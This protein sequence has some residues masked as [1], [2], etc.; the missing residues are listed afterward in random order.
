MMNCYVCD[1]SI[2]DLK[3][4]FKHL[5]DF[6]SISEESTEFKCGYKSCNKT[7]ATKRSIREHIMKCDFK[8][9]QNV[10]SSVT[11]SCSSNFSLSEQN[12]SPQDVYGNSDLYFKFINETRVDQ[13]PSNELPTNTFEAKMKNEFESNVKLKIRNLVATLSTKLLPNCII[14]LTIKNIISILESVFLYIRSNFLLPNVRFME[15]YNDFVGFQNEILHEIKSLSTSYRRRKAAFENVPK[16][17]EVTLGVRFDRKFDKKLQMFIEKPIPDNLIYISLISTL[18]YLFNDKSVQQYISEGKFTE[19]GIYRDISDGSFMKRS[20]FYNVSDKRILIHI[21][22]DDFETVNGLGYK[23]GIH[24][25]TPIYFVIKNLPPYLQS[26]LQNIH[27]L[28]L[29]NAQDTKFYGYNN[30]LFCVVQELKFLE[31]IGIEIDFLQQKTLKGSLVALSGDYIGANGICGMVESCRAENFCRICLVDHS[32]MSTVFHESQVTLRTKEEHFAHAELAEKTNSIVNGVK[33]SCILNE[34][35]YFNS[36]DAP[37]CDIMHDILEGVGQWDEKTFFTF[38]TQNKILTQLEIN[39]KIAAFNFGTLESTSLPNSVSFDKTGVGLKAAQT[40][41]LIRHT[42]L[43]FK[44]I[45][46]RNDDAELKNV[47]QLVVLLNQIM[48]IIFAPTITEEMIQNLEILIEV[49]H[50]LYLLCNAEK[51]LKPK[52]HFMIHYPNIIRKMGPLILLWC[53]RFEGKHLPFKKLA[54]CTQNFV[55]IC[56]TFAFRHQESLYFHERN[57]EIDKNKLSFE[58]DTK[59]DCFKHLLSSFPANEIFFLKTITSNETF[60]RGYFV[61]TG[62]NKTTKLLIFEQIKEIF[63]FKEEIY[64]VLTVFTTESFDLNLNAYAIS[65]KEK[66]SYSICPL[67]NLFYHAPFERLLVDKKDYIVT[68]HTII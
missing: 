14:D 26:K 10:I 25:T 35:K 45:F 38:L 24:K 31:D 2:S 54:Q 20:T 8:V 43:I 44:S 46:E 50:K 49:H 56:K 19:D 68:K 18:K 11:E 17:Q 33:Y 59:T 37:T 27:L 57:F 23:T 16:P 12:M 60:K 15:I 58:K 40:W 21:Y 66:D 41:C 5:K 7:T 61:C 42:P 30:I 3:A 55:N 63:L 48:N 62:L 34:L 13:S 4:F 1:L 32:N 67:K 29:A 28:A 65:Q 36:I 22:M 6:H 9:N 64:L 39:D 53:M 51:G 52:H 47:C